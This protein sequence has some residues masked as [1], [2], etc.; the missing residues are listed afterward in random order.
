MNYEQLVPQRLDIFAFIIFL[1]VVQGIFF[2]YFLLRKPKELG[3]KNTYLGL[4]L[5]TYSAVLLEVFL[6]YTGLIVHS[7]W[8]V[9][10]SE[11]VNFLYGPILYFLIL[12]FLH[13]ELPKRHKL[14]YLPF[15]VYLLYMGFFFLQGADH[16]FNA[17]IDAYFPDMEHIAATQSFPADPLGIKKY[18]NP[19]S[20]I[21]TAIYIYMSQATIAQSVRRDQLKLF[22]GADKE[23][24]W[25]RNLLTLGLISYLFWVIKSFTGLRDVQDHLGATLHTIVIYFVGFGILRESIIAPRKAMDKYSRS[26]LSAERKQR[27]IQRLDQLSR[28]DSYYLNNSLSMTDLAKMTS[29]TNHHLSQVL[30]EEL[31][32][33]Y[34]EYISGLRIEYAKKLL[35]EQPNVKIEEIA[36]QAGFN[37]K[38]TF[39]TAFKKLS[40]FTPSEFRAQSGL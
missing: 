33:S 8:L 3:P 21:Y 29:T 27:I 40:D 6:C 23:I 2:S 5:L 4:F 39:N 30:N 22:K 24:A 10:Y 19:I 38:S 15:I 25:I 13:K 9:D 11:P 18:I 37:S 16:K 34:T 12:S 31:G 14:H 20:V 26:S 17:Y 35:I 1:G 28:E 32:K 7:L 36:E